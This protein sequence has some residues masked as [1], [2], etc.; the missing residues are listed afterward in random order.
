MAVISVAYTLLAG[1]LWRSSLTGFSGSMA[2]SSP[3]LPCSPHLC[4]A[5]RL[6]S[7]H[8]FLIVLAILVCSWVCSFHSFLIVMCD[9]SLPLGNALL[10]YTL[11]TEYDFSL[12]C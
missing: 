6:C 12:C 11:L 9:P 1:S 3:S 5:V 8:S 2:L 7:F 4:L 10:R